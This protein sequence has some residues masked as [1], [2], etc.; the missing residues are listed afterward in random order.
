MKMKLEQRAPMCD[1]PECADQD[2]WV[3]GGGGSGGGLSTPE[4][5][6]DT[7]VIWAINALILTSL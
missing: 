2:H 3:V 5:A 4:Q 1:A 7:P 6:I